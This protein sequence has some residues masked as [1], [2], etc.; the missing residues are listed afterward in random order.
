MVTEA[1]YRRAEERERMLNHLQAA[2]DRLLADNAKLR[3]ARSALRHTL[4]EVLIHG[5]VR[6]DAAGLVRQALKQT[7]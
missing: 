5:D 2:L 1:Q 6:D 4:E 7:Q 3:E